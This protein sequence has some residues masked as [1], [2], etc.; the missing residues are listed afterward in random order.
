MNVYNVL[1]I[2]RLEVRKAVWIDTCPIDR[3]R[4]PGSTPDEGFSFLN[5][6]PLSRIGII[7]N[8]LLRRHLLK[9]YNGIL[10]GTSEL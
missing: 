9:I 3:A 2:V 8:R 6:G 10:F 1:H 7:F 5:E 4:A